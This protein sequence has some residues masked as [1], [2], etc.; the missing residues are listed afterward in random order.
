MGSSGGASTECSARQCVQR[1]TPP[2]ER[3]G[4]HTLVK[5]SEVVEPPAD[6]ISFSPSEILPAK[7]EDKLEIEKEENQNDDEAPPEKAGESDE[8]TEKKEEEKEEKK[9]EPDNEETIETAEKGEEKETEKTDAVA[10]EEAEP[11]A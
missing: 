11:E 4:L 7:S 10:E 2:P 6:P 5:M 3:G 9:D 8:I 1:Q